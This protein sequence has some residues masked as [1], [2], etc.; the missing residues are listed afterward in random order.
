MP[1]ILS[2]WIRRRNW[3]APLGSDGDPIRRWDVDSNGMITGPG[4][5]KPVNAAT[6][7]KHIESLYDLRKYFTLYKTEYFEGG[8]LHTHVSS[9]REGG[10]MHTR[11][12]GQNRS[13]PRSLP[14]WCDKLQFECKLLGLNIALHGSANYAIGTLPGDTNPPLIKARGHRLNATHYDPDKGTP[15]ESPMRTMM[16][17]RLRGDPMPGRVPAIYY[18]LASVSEYR[19]RLVFR[20]KGGLPGYSIARSVNPKLITA[21]EF[22][23]PTVTSRIAWTQYYAHINRKYGRGLEAS[24]AFFDKID[25]YDY[26]TVEQIEWAKAE[27]QRHIYE[28]YSPNSK[29]VPRS[30]RTLDEIALKRYNEEYGLDDADYFEDEDI[31]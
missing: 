7:T 25:N 22:N 13:V 20:D 30:I 28:D 2:S 19:K 18:K 4:L 11:V 17:C 3:T 6:A 8:S 5:D 12:Y 15:M 29:R 21:T 16:L 26:M 14:S 27:I 23:F 10:C 9:P 1:N 24:Y 31:E